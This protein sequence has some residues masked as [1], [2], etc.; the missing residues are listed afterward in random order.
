M[1][2]ILL[3]F[4][5]ANILVYEDDDDGDGKY[6]DEDKNNDINTTSTTIMAKTTRTKIAATEMTMTTAMATKRKI[7]RER[8][9]YYC[10]GGIV[11]IH[12]LQEVEWFPLCA[13]FVRQ[14]LQK[15]KICK[16]SIEKNILAQFVYTFLLDTYFTLGLISVLSFMI[17]DLLLLRN[18]TAYQ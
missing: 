6:Y 3:Y 10:E 13:S 12:T 14:P 4:K 9:V 1:N 2:A 18:V 7:K 11:T 8:M 17:S 15:Q 16:C 5:I